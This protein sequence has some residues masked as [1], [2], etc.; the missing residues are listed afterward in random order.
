MKILLYFFTVCFF[1]S[2]KHKEEKPLPPP[3]VKKEKSDTTASKRGPI[4]NL[5]DSLEQKRIILCFKDSASTSAG[6]SI[7]LNNIYNKKI[8]DAA[9]AGKVKLTGQPIAWYKTQKAPFFFEAGIPVDKA[10]AK[11]TKGMYIKKTGTGDSVLIAHFFGPYELTGTG[12][13]A[14]NEAL[15]DRKKKKSAPAYEIYIN[16][17]FDGRTKKIDPYKMQTDIVMPYH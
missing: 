12:Y 4:I 5:V 1:I 11:P 15:K 3:L 7:K 16:N 17:P 2:C 9:K 14:L 6:M 8:P 13:E 10:P